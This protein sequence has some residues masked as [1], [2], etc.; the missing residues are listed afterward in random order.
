MGKGANVV[1]S[2]LHHFFANHLLGEEHVH[3]HAD[4]C[5]RQNK[6]NTVIQVQHNKV[7]AHTLCACIF[8]MCMYVKLTIIF[9]SHLSIYYGGQWLVFTRQ[10]GCLS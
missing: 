8:E 7:D 1:V 5:V 6:N 9:V 3:L 10:S 2:M 4:N